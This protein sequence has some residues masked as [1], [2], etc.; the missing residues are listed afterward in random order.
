MKASK[1][2]QNDKTIVCGHWH[3]SYGHAVIEGIG[4]E[5]GVGA[6]FAPYY[7]NGIIAIDACAAYSGF[8]NCLVIE[9]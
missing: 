9:D 6:I 8:E 7:G 4:P 3:A 1:S 5:F 2:V